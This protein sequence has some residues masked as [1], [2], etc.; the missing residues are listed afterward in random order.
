MGICE[1]LTII[2]VVCKF[3]GIIT[4]AWWIVLLPEL[5]AIAFYIFWLVFVVILGVVVHKN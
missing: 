5:I 2:F 4:W 3:I 1:I